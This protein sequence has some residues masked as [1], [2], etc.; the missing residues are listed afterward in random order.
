MKQTHSKVPTFA[1]LI[2]GVV[3]L[4][5][6][7]SPGIGLDAVP[8]PEATLVGT[9]D[10]QGMRATGFWD[11]VADLAEN[12]SAG[13]GESTWEQFAFIR[14]V[15]DSTDLT[16]D[17]LLEIRVALRSTDDG[18]RPVTGFQLARPLTPEMTIAVL[19]SLA[20]Q[21][22]RRISILEVDH[23][24]GDVLHV[25]LETGVDTES[26]W[27][28]FAPDATVVYQGID[29]EILS[30]M[31][32][33]D[34][35]QAAPLSE[36]LA[37]LGE[38]VSPEAQAW[39]AYTVSDAQRGIIAEMFAEDVPAPLQGLAQSLD[40]FSSSVVEFQSG[41]DLEVRLRWY[42]EGDDKA[43]AFHDSMGGLTELFKGLVAL[44]SGGRPIDAVNS[45]TLSRSDRMV[46]LG[47]HVS[48][49]D[50]L[51]LEELYELNLTE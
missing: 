37:R 46:M 36:E 7:S 18:I 12:R 11:S 30:V 45:M 28:G 33:L 35:G 13:L 6:C 15:L 3:A 17:D 16:A 41:D 43:Q 49:K 27:I 24:G 9:I 8:M 39:L 4:A 2:L 40:A 29:E 23:P 32:R 22:D 19:E 20:A 5:G 10:P 1:A 21:Y 50:L 51:T 26:L 31:D 42:F 38:T 47:L 14:Q 48:Q 25:E 34:A 44:A